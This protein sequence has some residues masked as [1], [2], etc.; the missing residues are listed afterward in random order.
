MDQAAT[1]KDLVIIG[2]QSE[3]KES[4]KSGWLVGVTMSIVVITVVP[5]IP[6]LIAFCIGLFINRNNKG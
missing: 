1:V 6:I 2:E 5:L 4:F 3:E